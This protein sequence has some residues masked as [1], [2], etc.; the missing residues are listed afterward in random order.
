VTG[1]K[2]ARRCKSIV[3]RAKALFRDRLPK[4]FSRRHYHYPPKN[5][6][7]LKH[8]RYELC[9]RKYL[10]RKQDHIFRE[11]ELNSFATAVEKYDTVLDF[12][13]SFDRSMEH[14]SHPLYFSSTTDNT[15]VMITVAFQ[16]YFRLFVPRCVHES[17]FEWYDKMQ[18]ECEFV[19]LLKIYK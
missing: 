4:R 19:R 13:S 10:R 14:P 11:L 12:A 1:N 2:N 16:C 17:H 8:L 15:F 3:A 5:S 18:S 9:P 6:S 7:L